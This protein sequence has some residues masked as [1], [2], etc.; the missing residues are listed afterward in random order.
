[1]SRPAGRQAPL[2]L[3]Y[4]SVAATHK[5]ARSLNEDRFLERPEVGLWAVADGMGGH[6]AGE[7]AAGMVVDALA[8]IDRFGSGYHGLNAVSQALQ[9]VNAVLIERAAGIGPGA[10]IGSTVA[11]LLVHEGHYACLWAGDSRAYLSRGGRLSQI[12]Q[13]HS[14]V[15]EMIDAGA[16]TPEQ[17]R[18]HGRANIITRAVGVTQPLAL[19]MLHAAIEPGDVFLLCSDGLTGAVEDFEIEAALRTGEL[20]PAAEALMQLALERGAPDNVTLVLI[21]ADRASVFDPQG[22]PSRL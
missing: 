7:V 10:L 1:L 15:Q 13:D 11:A 2:P 20:E 16:L 18:T 6:Q 22:A 19:D 21:R 9:A 8:R 14:L 12:S 4:K 3:S 5:G 17:S